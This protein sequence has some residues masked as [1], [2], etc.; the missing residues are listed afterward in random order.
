M[1]EPLTVD[2]SDTPA[3]V[4]T[5]F[6]HYW[7]TTDPSLWPLAMTSAKE[8]LEGPHHGAQTSTRK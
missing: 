5:R 7:I 6:A 4:Y 1:E 8:E 2:V 3:N